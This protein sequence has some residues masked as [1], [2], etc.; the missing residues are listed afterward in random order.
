MPGKT[1]YVHPK[2]QE[3]YC[4]G[5]AFAASGGTLVYASGLTGEEESDTG[6]TWTSRIPG[7][8][9]TVILADPGE[10]DATLAITEVGT[11]VVVSL[12]TDA[13]SEPES[14][15][16]D[17]I[18]EAGGEL[19]LVTVANTGASTGV[20]VVEV[21]TTAL[22]GA[23]HPCS[24]NAPDGLAFESGFASYVADPDGVERDCCADEYGAGY[25]N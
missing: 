6:L 16:A 10:A 1:D 22:Y 3:A 12:G 24:P 8:G 5:R 23:T 19:T 18:A 15:A 2:D 11:V 17:I 21:E 4:E 14:T 13:Q 7:D 20:G 25:G 9:V